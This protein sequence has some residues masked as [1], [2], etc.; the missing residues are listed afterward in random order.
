MLYHRRFFT[1]TTVVSNYNKLS[2]CSFWRMEWLTD[3]SSSTC[4]ITCLISPPQAS[5]HTPPNTRVPVW[6]G[7]TIQVTEGWATSVKWAFCL[8]LPLCLPRTLET[9]IDSLQFQCEEQMFGDGL[10]MFV[11]NA[12]YS[13]RHFLRSNLCIVALRNVLDSHSHPCKYILHSQYCHKSHS[14]KGH[15]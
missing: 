14:N 3:L 9:L 15:K 10:L 2:D 13:C 8:L 6:A 4:R 1:K 7:G 11:W 5:E 12:E